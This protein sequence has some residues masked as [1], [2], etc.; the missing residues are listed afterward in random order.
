MGF[1]IAKAF[2]FTI[3]EN[4]KTPIISTSQRG[5][6]Y[7]IH[8]RENPSGRPGPPGQHSES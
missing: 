3:M 6:P 8:G 4:D 5:I 7:E 1:R 2:P